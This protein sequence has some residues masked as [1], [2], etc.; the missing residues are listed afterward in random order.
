METWFVPNATAPL[1][2]ARNVLMLAPHPDD[3][4]FGCGGSAAL[5]VQAGA[6]V[7]PHI[8]TDGGGYLEGGQRAAAVALR[9]DESHRAA[10]ILGTAEPT[11]GAW[12]DRQLNTAHDLPGRLGELI[13]ATAADVVF[14]PSLW[15]V[16]PDHRATAW[17]AVRAVSALHAARG[18]APV[19]AFYEV[20]APLRPNHLVDISTV[21]DLKRR[22][23]ATFES[24]LAQQRY[25]VHIAALNTFR[26]Y[27][28]VGG[29]AAAEALIVVDA[30]QL[31]EWQ[32]AYAQEG[33]PGLAQM[34]ETALQKANA[35][36]EE[37][38]QTL[39]GLN[40]RLE[41]QAG[42]L[43][44]IP[45][46]VGELQHARAELDAARREMQARDL[47]RDRLLADTRRALDDVL[48]S[49]SWRITRPLRWLGERLRQS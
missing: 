35:A 25:D 43:A 11:F 10:Q 33:P 38:V 48:A 31:D 15:E 2:Q 6:T 12:Q 39:S 47:V 37:A 29:V 7:Q 30:G 17:A 44:R 28:L 49:R 16:H 32:S 20:G 26:T 1:P 27:T 24:Q 3:E 18:A 5:Y 46:L 21:V 4:V 40:R 22:A 19:L 42:E 8:L 23:M 14:A 9:R 45:G 13:E 34:T 41:E 36:A